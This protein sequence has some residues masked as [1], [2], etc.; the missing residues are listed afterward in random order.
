MDAQ[1]LRQ[2]INDS[3]QLLELFK[4]F[5][6]YKTFFQETPL[7]C[8]FALESGELRESLHDFCFSDL[9]GAIAQF[10]SMLARA[11][12]GNQKAMLELIVSADKLLQRCSDSDNIPPPEDDL[13][14]VRIRKAID[15]ATAQ[16]ELTSVLIQ[17]TSTD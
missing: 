4:L 9:E 12:G 16:Y 14:L 10:H 13:E 3:R 1:E 15:V 11:I 6:Q 17:P 7:L 8:F 5:E 2:K